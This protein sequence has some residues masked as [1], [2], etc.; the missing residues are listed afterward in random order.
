VADLDREKAVGNEIVEFEHIADRR[1]NNRAGPKL[2]RIALLHGLNH[3]I[4]RHCQAS[5]EVFA[6][7]T[8]MLSMWRY[9]NRY[10]SISP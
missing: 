5:R 7:S 2:W 8:N 1:S 10:G 6:P 9:V 3:F 4:C